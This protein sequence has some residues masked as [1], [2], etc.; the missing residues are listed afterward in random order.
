[1]GKVQ[2][3]CCFIKQKNEITSESKAKL[4]TGLPSIA[5]FRTLFAAISALITERRTISKQNQLFLV[6]MKLRHGL[7]NRDLAYIG[8]TP[9][10][11][12]SFVSKMYNG[13]ISDEEI[14]ERS[15]FY[16]NV[17]FGDEIMA[18]RGFTIANELA[19]QGAT[20]VIP[21]FLKGRKRLPGL[22]V[23]RA[24]QL[25]SLRIHVERSIERIKNYAILSRTIPIF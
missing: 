12:M 8:I 14:T 17:E 7:Q 23:D 5:A 24:R 21:P 10:G 16:T 22:L 2:S 11:S 9:Y 25:S 13:R 4:Y 15:G 3:R 19:K 18:D 20:L 6:L 1:M